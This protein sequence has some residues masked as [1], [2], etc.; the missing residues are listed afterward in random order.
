MR[1]DAAR[2]HDPGREGSRAAAR[3]VGLTKRYADVVAVDHLDLEVRAG[4]CFGVLGPNGAGKTT[5]VE[6]LEGLTTPDGGTVEVLGEAWGRGHDRALR[7]RLGVQLQE[8]QL[9]EK[10]TV[11]ETMRLFRS[12]Y[13]RGRD[14]EELL[15]LVSL[16]EKR[17]ALV[18]KLSGGQKQRL[19]LACALAGSPELLFLDE[20]TTGLD[21]QAR[22]QLWD[23]VENFRAGG[24]TILLTTHY[25]EEAARLCDRVAIMDH[26][27]VIALDT[28]AAL[29]ASLGAE[30]IVEMSVAGELSDGEVTRLGGVT[31]VRRHEGGAY[32]LT[33][34]D[35]ATALPALLDELARQ[36]VK[37]ETLSTHEATLEDV[38]VSLTGRNLRDG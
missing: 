13:R 4:E 38:F 9:S 29:V 28:P 10:V 12:F 25:M 36:G 22:L 19:A 1:D 17:G 26:G 14:V 20:P 34:G 21:P 11:A 6:I 35:I 5:T 18:G 2:S 23:I 24:G 32:S 27:R 8:T 3:C 16:E 30:Q 7:E 31:G 15:R 37:L 33:V